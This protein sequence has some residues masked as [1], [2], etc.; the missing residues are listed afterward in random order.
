M[1]L[2]IKNPEE[3]IKGLLFRNKMVM[4]WLE[5]IPNTMDV[6]LSKLGE[7]VKD[8]ETW[9]AAVHGVTKSRTELSD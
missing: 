7:I 9:R 2:V 5:S 3:L 6:S 4:R 8:G 1:Y